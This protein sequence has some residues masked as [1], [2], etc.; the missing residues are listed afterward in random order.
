[1]ESDVDVLLVA[2]MAVVVN[3]LIFRN[4]ASGNRSA[5]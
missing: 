2:V 3:T 5:W 4:D 1:M